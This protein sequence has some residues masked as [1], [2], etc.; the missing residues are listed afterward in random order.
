[1][2]IKTIGD[3]SCSLMGE[4]SVQIDNDVMPLIDE[5]CE[6]AFVKSALGFR[7]KTPTVATNLISTLFRA[8]AF[9]PRALTVPQNVVVRM[10]EALESKSTTFD[11]A[12]IQM[13]TDHDLQVFKCS[14]LVLVYIFRY[15]TVLRRMAIRNWRV[16]LV[17]LRQFIPEESDADQ[18]AS[19]KAIAN[20]F[21]MDVLETDEEYVWFKSTKRI[22]EEFM[23]ELAYKKGDKYFVGWMGSPRKH[24]FVDAL[25]HWHRCTDFSDAFVLVRRAHWVSLTDAQKIIDRTTKPIIWLGRPHLAEEGPMYFM[26][27]MCVR[28]LEA[29]EPPPKKR[30]TVKSIVEA[31]SELFKTTCTFVIVSSTEITYH[32]KKRGIWYLLGTTAADTNRERL[33]KSAP[34]HYPHTAHFNV[35]T[36]RQFKSF[37]CSVDWIVYVGKTKHDAE[38]L[39]EACNVGLMTVE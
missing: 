4:K 38:F 25:D 36:V 27:S 17:R 21:A 39:Y 16:S 31:E 37:K 35:G 23:A 34:A 28:P 30:I 3:A 20:L 22:M 6:Y 7:F 33:I 19:L 10:C 32:T 14:N 13:F 1:M 11:A 12:T 2:A 26:R 24:V 5:R 15:L 18:I 8:T 29:I 9:N